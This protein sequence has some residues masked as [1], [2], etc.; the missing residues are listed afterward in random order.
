[1]LKLKIFLNTALLKFIVNIIK[2]NIFYKIG[3]AANTGEILYQCNVSGCKN[4]TDRQEY[5]EQDI[6]IIQRFQQ[7]VRAVEARTGH[8]R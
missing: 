3:V 7:T 4:N 1:M 5:V 2:N 6:I 8:E